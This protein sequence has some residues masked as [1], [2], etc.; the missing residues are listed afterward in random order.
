MACLLVGWL[1]G[2]L[3][4]WLVGWLVGWFVGLSSFRYSLVRWK[5]FKEAS[6]PL[7]GFSIVDHFSYLNL[8]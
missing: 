6:F 8:K 4:S 7:Y 2:Q 3:V 5:M 1:V